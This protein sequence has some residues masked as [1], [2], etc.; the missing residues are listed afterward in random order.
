M[1]VLMLATHDLSGGAAR[2]SY[3]IHRGLREAGVDSRLLVRFKSSDD[4]HVIGPV[5]KSQKLRATM[6]RQLELLPLRCYPK[7]IGETFSPGGWSWPQLL[8]VELGAFQ[9]EL[10]N[11]HWIAQGFSAISLLGRIRVPIVWTLQDMWAMTGGC[12]YVAGCAG[13]ASHC[14]SCPQL[15]SHAARDLSQRVMRRK[16]AA[17]QRSDLSIVP[18]SQWMDERVASSSLL[19]ARP[20]EIIPNGLDTALYQPT[21]KIQARALWGLPTDR[22][23]ILFGAIHATQDRRKGFALLAE[24]LRS[25]D[26]ADWR[27]GVQV[28]VFGSSQA[29]DI[30]GPDL[31]V[32][33][34]GHLHDDLSLSLLYAAADVM[35]VPS[36]EEAFGQTASEAMACGTPVVAFDK[37]GVADIVRHHETGYLAQDFSAADLAAGIQWVLADATRH[38]ALCAAARTR[39]VEKFDL[40]VVVRSYVNLFERTLARGTR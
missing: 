34:V 33:A 1:K 11:P 13:Y 15:G 5:G 2:A 18:I 32:R 8:D 16:R 10:V 28:V 29:E 35:I 30:F 39:A 27:R 24:A 31:P 40:R 12:H 14:G 26:D 21:D 23:I 9:P 7:N 19:S 17:W 38:R 25:I 36:T 4:P 20:R 6:Q 3:R 37:T 22:K